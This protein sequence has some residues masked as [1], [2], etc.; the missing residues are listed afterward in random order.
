M[1]SRTSRP[2][3]L[4][5]LAFLPARVRLLNVLL[6]RGMLGFW[7]YPRKCGGASGSSALFS[8]LRKGKLFQGCSQ[9][10]RLRR[11]VAHYINVFQHFSAK[12]PFFKLAL[13]SVPRLPRFGFVS[14][15]HFPLVSSPSKALLSL[16]W[17]RCARGHTLAT[18]QNLQ[19]TTHKPRTHYVRFPLFDECSVRSIGLIRFQNVYLYMFS[20]NISRPLLFF[21]PLLL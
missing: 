16:W 18:T 6:P 4:A 12:P 19:P 3:L 14:N 15:L 21:L 13:S 11:H 1:V 17:R 20:P 9:R 7:C 8:P 2:A 10:P 5:L